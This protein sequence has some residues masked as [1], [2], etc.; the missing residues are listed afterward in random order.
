MKYKIYKHTSPSNKVYIGQTSQE[1]IIQRWRNGGKGYFRMDKYGNYQQPAMVNAINKYPW[2][3]WKHEIID[4]CDTQEEADL[5]EIKYIEKYNSTN[6]NFGYNITKGGGGHSGQ[7]M[8]QETK[9]KLSSIIKEKWKNDIEYREK[10]INGLKG[11]PMSENTRNAL[12]K[13]NVGRKM[14]DET[15]NKISKANGNIVLQFSLTGD[16]INEYQSASKAGQFIG[17]TTTS[18][19]NSC[20]GFT[21]KCGEY[22]FIYKKDYD[23]NP[24]ILQDRINNLKIRKKSAKPIIQMSLDGNFIKEWP[25]T[26]DASESLGISINNINNCLRKRSKTAGKFKWKYK[27]DN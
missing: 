23:E 15:K 24:N 27:N 20:S 21:K 2:D 11:I 19:T 13:A 6:R 25:S 17:K 16:F 14:T 18:I 22:L 7:P 26:T 8:K 9:D 1:N 10:C 5:L 4:E 12:L 3:T